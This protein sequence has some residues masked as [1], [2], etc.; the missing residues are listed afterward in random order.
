MARD[1]HEKYYVS[2]C[3]PCVSIVEVGK[4]HC[5]RHEHF[6]EARV[7]YVAIV[8]GLSPSY[9]RVAV[10]KLLVWAVRSQL[11][12]QKK[13]NKNDTDILTYPVSLNRSKHFTLHSRADVYIPTPNRLLREAFSHIAFQNCCI[14]LPE[15][16]FL[17]YYFHH[18]LVLIIYTGE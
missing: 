6:L 11:H 17:T 8:C 3:L 15:D 9:I 10:G 7:R 1:L 13:V 5:D 4:V 2:N 18:C 12:V 14:F 16:C